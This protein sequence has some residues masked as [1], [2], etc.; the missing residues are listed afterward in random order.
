MQWAH[1]QLAILR[2]IRTGLILVIMISVVLLP[3]AAAG[4]AG[5]LQV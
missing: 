5:F 4:T 2:S 3:L 1:L